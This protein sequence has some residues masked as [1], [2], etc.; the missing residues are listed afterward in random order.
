[1]RGLAPSVG[2]AALALGLASCGGGSTAST[3]A[4]PPPPPPPAATQSA[5]TLNVDRCLNQRFGTGTVLSTLVPDVLTDNL[6]LPSGFPNGR[7]PQDPVI[8]QLLAGLLLDQTRHT[9]NTLVNVPLNPPGV[10]KPISTVFP[11]LA[12]PFGAP[13]P[14]VQGGTNFNFRTDAPEAYT[15][16]ERG[17]VPAVATALISGPLRVPYNESSPAED[18]TQRW[19]GDMRTT[20]TTI[21]NQLNDDLQRLG[22]TSCSI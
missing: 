1:M 15:I 3:L 14:N 10:D 21:H 5:Q 4:A 8:D 17:S 20:L 18:V 13:P 16:V 11:F 2:L 7:L 12:P 9:I 6:N 22:L 19:T